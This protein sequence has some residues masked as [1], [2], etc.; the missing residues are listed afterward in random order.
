MNIGTPQG[1]SL[2]FIIL[3]DDLNLWTENRILSNFADDMQSIIISESKKK[4]FR[5]YWSAI[6]G[7]KR[8]KMRSLMTMWADIRLILSIQI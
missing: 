7:Q 5:N 1:S 6:K 4:S 8:T 3:M 2:L